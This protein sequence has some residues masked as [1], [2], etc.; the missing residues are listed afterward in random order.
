MTIQ[1]ATYNQWIILECKKCHHKH[2]LFRE[3][4]K[5]TECCSC[6]HPELIILTIDKYSAVDFLYFHKENQF[7]NLTE[8]LYDK[9]KVLCEKNKIS[10][11]IFAE[12][13]KII[14]DEIYELQEI[15]F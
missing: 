4:T 10:D 9:I 6:Q 8:N 13:S 11:K 1:D 3:F 15:I 14:S 12:L 2:Y 5:Q 7:K